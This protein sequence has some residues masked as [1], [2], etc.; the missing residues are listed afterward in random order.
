MELKSFIGLDEAIA[1]AR[2]FGPYQKSK[3]VP[4]LE[5]VGR[6][7]YQD[8]RSPSDFPPFD[9]SAVDGY[10]LNSKETISSTKTNPSN[11]RMVGRIFP[12]S[13]K[14]FNL[15]EGEALRIATGSKVP[16]GAD[17]IVMLEDASE[18]DGKIQVF[19][20]V[21]KYQN[22]SKKGEDLKKG[23]KILSRGERIYPPHVAALLECGIEKIG[24]FS[25]SIGIIS[26][27]DEL[28]SRR[29]RNSTQ[30]MI[31]SYFLRK[32]FD[33]VSHGVIPDNQN[34]I[35]KALDSIAE[36]IIIV[37]GGTG[38]GERDILPSLIENSGRLVFRGLKIRPG[39]TTSFGVFKGKPV[40][41]VSGLPVAALI[42][43]EN[44]ILEMI[45]K[46]LGLRNEEKEHRSG[47]LGRSLVN[48][49]GFR[50]FVRVKTMT[51]NGKTIVY[52]T[53]VTGSGV[54]YSMIGAD[55][56]L[57]MD[58]NTEGIEEGEIVNFEVLRW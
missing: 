27:G 26:T 24:I 30:P 25:L 4:L 10:A 33:A 58:E 32:G 36:D 21:R 2:N 45:H 16:K 5:A 17:A 38:P 6:F 52:P 46:W 42:A 39:R 11:F 13:T 40:F 12:S 9:R 23:F 37:T 57:V 31:Q 44:V 34:V 7:S 50:S 51:K 1:R 29:V 49:L 43:S 3:V 48:T 19:V 55:G 20:P 35:E 56:I 14:S 15:A 22:I 8:V 41:M 54:I 28:V 47:L 53:R 18:N